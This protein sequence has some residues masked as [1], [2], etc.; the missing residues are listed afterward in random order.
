MYYNRHICCRLVTPKSVIITFFIYWKDLLLYFL[1]NHYLLLTFLKNEMLSKLQE[2]LASSLLDFLFL[3][4]SDC[5]EV[6]FL[7]YKKNIFNICDGKINVVQVFRWQ[8][9][10]FLSFWKTFMNTCLIF[11]HWSL[12]DFITKCE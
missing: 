6:G 5:L 11:A 4:Q 3:P 8:T 9:S 1:E 7:F 10:G 2:C 12:S